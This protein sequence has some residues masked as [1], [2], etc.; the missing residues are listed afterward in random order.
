M[1][2]EIGAISE[3]EVRENRGEAW[4]T[5]RHGGGEHSSTRGSLAAVL[6]CFGWRDS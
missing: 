6:R 1:R 4:T 2:V 3:S 5:L